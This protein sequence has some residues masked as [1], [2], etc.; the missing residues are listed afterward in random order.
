MFIYLPFFNWHFW[1]VMFNINIERISN[2][3]V[4]T[5][6]QEFKCYIYF[7]QINIFKLIWLYYFSFPKNFLNLIIFL[8][9]FKILLLNFW[10]ERVSKFIHFINKKNK[11][12]FFLSL[13]YLLKVIM[14]ILYLNR[15]NIEK[16]AIQIFFKNWILFYLF[17]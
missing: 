4:L 17:F 6:T 16:Y 7:N 8:V 1:V 3:L 9:I 2:W 14:L 11:T 12:F 10:K 13:L 15:H 5:F